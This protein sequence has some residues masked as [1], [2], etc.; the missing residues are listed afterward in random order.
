LSETDGGAKALEALDALDRERVSAYQPYWVTRANVLEKL[1]RKPEAKSAFDRAIG[2]TEDE[3]VR[4]YLSDR[5]S[6]LP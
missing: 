3:T 5:K 4:R 2:L 1:G 6:A